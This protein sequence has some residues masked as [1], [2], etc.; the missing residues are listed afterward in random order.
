MF[1]FL[2]NLVLHLVAVIYLPVWL[3]SLLKKNKYKD[4]FKER[5][6]FIKGPFPSDSHSS[7]W[8]H[9]VSVGE[10]KSIARL[11]RQIKSEHKIIFLIISTVTETGQAEARELI[12]EADKIFYL[13]YDFSE[14]IVKVVKRFKPK[15]LILSETDLW[16]NLQRSVRKQ[17]GK[18]VLVSGKLS[19]RSARRY[20]KLRFFSKRL[21]E[22]IDVIGVQTEMYAQRFL[23]L[24]GVK[25]KVEV[26]G[27]LKYD[28]HFDHLSENE[29]NILRG[30]LGIKA[31]ERVVVLGSSHPQEEELFIRQMQ[32]V[33]ELKPGVKFVIVPRHP[34]RFD[35]VAFLLN[36]FKISFLRYSS[37]N[38]ESVS[39]EERVVLLD[40]MGMLRHLYQVAHLA[41]VGGSFTGLVG[42]HN[43]LEPVYYG[44]PV[45][46]GPYMFA[47]EEM[48]QLVLAH[49]V[50]VS[51]S[52]DEVSI[53]IL[54][55]LNNADKMKGFGERGL[56]LCDSLKGSLDKTY[57]RVVELLEE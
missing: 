29:K 37:L 48:E 52:I 43:I 2:Y 16:W 22:N 19:Q 20:K 4:S 47:Q 6:G 31:N 44:V 33:W 32:K 56:S 7:I 1:L 9:G 14:S 36:R 45:I 15:I 27:N 5:L 50:G 49:N 39:N 53:F 51:S 28:D 57:R 24:E 11:A 26:L 55:F 8:I 34:E 35:E 30:E 46:F 13:P 3:W 42:G 17:G 23:S 25:G 12:P 54:D 21:F 38:K 40:R 18:V 41:V 10:I